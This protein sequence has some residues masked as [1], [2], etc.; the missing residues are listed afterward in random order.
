EQKGKFLLGERL[1][2]RGF[3]LPRNCQGTALIGDPRN[4]QNLIVAQLHLAFL[5]F[6]NAVLET[7]GMI[8]DGIQDEGRSDDQKL[9]NKTQRL[10]RWHYQWIILHEYLPL[11]VGQDV[12]DDILIRGRQFY[13]WEERSDYPFMPVEFSVAAFRFGHSQSQQVYRIND[14]VGPL[15]LL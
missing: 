4:D 15:P 12:V 11:I 14:V 1:G 6:H 7:A 3:D 9:F 8:H 5:R 13:R 2:E 10:V